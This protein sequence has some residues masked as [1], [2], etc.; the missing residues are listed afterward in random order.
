VAVT[1]SVEAS[2]EKIVVGLAVIVTDVTG[3]AFTVTVVVA[4]IVPPAPVAVAVYV[5]VAVGLTEVVPPA[6]DRVTL[7]PVPVTVTEVAFEAVTVKVLDAPELIVVG[8]A[9]MVTVGGVFFAVLPAVH[10]TISSETARLG[11]ATERSRVKKWRKHNCFKGISF[12][13]LKGSRQLLDAPQ[14]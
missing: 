4:V 8:L 6:G 11:I 13:S 1:V 14:T 12:I 7:V 3:T 10:P 9:E 2:P 5:V